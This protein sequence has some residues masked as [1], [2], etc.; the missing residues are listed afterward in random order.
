MSLGHEKQRIT[1]M[2]CA[3]ADGTKLLP[4]VLIPRKNALIPLVEEFRGKLV[5]KFE[6]TN[7]MNDK[8]CKD[9]VRAIF[10]GQPTFHKQL[11]IW[12]S[13]TPHHSKEM[14]ELLKSLN[15]VPAI[16]PGMFLFLV[17]IVFLLFVF[18]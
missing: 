17:Y 8:L 6:G 13:F 5:L 18:T 3:K 16:I 4:F 14:L 1:V 9:F 2:L 7:W 11:L 15:V 12:D 10:A